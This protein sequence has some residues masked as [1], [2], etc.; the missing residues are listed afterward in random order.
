MS[1]NSKARH[2]CVKMGWVNALLRVRFPVRKGN[3]GFFLTEECSPK[4]TV[5]FYGHKHPRQTSSF[6][7]M[8]YQF[9]VSIIRLPV[10]KGY[11]SSFFAVFSP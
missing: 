5:V 3:L 4:I 8:F 1:I 10:H 11:H 7:S 6:Y 9:G 2:A